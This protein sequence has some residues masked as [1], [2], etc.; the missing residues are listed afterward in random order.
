[1]PALITE[2]RL[3]FHQKLLAGNLTVDHRSIPANADSSNKTSITI[4]KKIIDKIGVSRTSDRVAGQTSGNTFEEACMD[5]LKKT[6]IHLTNLRP[7]DWTIKKISGRSGVKVFADF[8]QYSHLI[9]LSATA[10]QD[11]IL[12][13]ALGTAYTISP[14]VVITR[15]PLPDRIINYHG[16]IVDS[17]SA[18]RTPLREINNRLELLHAS[19]SA[20]WTIRSDR[21]QN[22]RT[23]ALSLIRNRK[24]HTP[25]IMVLTAEPLP[26]RLS[27][28]ALGTG[29]ID[30]VYHFALPELIESVKE[31]DNEEAISMLNIMVEGKRLKD[32]S[33]LPFD[34]AI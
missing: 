16:A 15:K 4:A 5:F 34:L 9:D 18:N 25:H 26:S 8:E 12:T 21:V 29:D 1:M 33:D 3:L 14:D 23:E 17:E 30:C 2:Q 28:I 11:P 13:A 20:K 22:A 27:S 7:G 31:L 19:I 6:F 24:G 10:K 32:I